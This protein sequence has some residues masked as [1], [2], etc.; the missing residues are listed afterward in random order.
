MA[1]VT[2]TML[3]LGTKAP[4]FNLPDTAGNTVSLAD[5]REASALLVVFMCNHCPYVKHIRETT[6]P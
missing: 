1:A 5:F 6:S 2:S 3:T 4:R